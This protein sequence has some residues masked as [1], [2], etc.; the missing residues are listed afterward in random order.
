MSDQGKTVT[1][2]ELHEAV[3]QTPI[4]KLAGVWGVSPASIVK[5]CETMNVPRPWSGHWTMV[6]RGWK[7]PKDA[8]PAGDPSTP[9]SIKIAARSSAGEEDSA[10]QERGTVKVAKDLRNAH[11]EVR[12]MREILADRFTD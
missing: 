10:K 8:L 6:R 1:R 12:K 5:A 7:M 4:T 2:E 11:L 9:A 3:W